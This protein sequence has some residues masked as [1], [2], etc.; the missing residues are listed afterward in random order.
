MNISSFFRSGSR[1][2]FFSGDTRDYAGMKKKRE[3]NLNISNLFQKSFPT[4]LAT[5]HL[6]SMGG[7]LGLLVYAGFED[8]VGTELLRLMT[9][10]CLGCSSYIYILWPFRV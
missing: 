4:S 5:E 7:L 3:L 2:R 1:G 9:E 6:Y 10:H 8:N